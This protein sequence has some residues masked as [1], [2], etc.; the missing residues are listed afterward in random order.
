MAATA[1]VAQVPPTRKST[2][3]RVQATPIQT[4]APRSGVITLYG[5]GIRIQVERGHLMLNDGIADERQ[6]FRLPRV[7]HELERL[8][9]IG[10]DGTVSLSALR[11]LSDQNA[12]FVMLDRDGKVV[13]VTGPVCPSDARLR[14]AQALSHSSD[15]AFCIAREL[16][17]RKLAGQEKVA[18]ETLSKPDVAQEIV[19]WRSGLAE[20]NTIDDVRRIE[21]QAAAEYWSAWRNLPITFPKLDLVR[22]P[23]HWRRFDTRKSVLS[24]SQRLATNPVNA[25]LNY[26]YAILEAESRL[27]LSAMGLD[28]G[29][30]FIHMDAPA[31]DSLACDLMESVRAQVDRYVLDWFLHH[32]L[33]REWFFE[34]RDGNCRL[35]APFAIQLSQTAR[36]WRHAVAPVAEWIARTLWKRE[37]PQSVAPPTRLTQARKRTAKRVSIEVRAPRTPKRQTLCRKCGKQIGEGHI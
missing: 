25:M 34:Q 27:A 29:L 15:R 20:A 1:T 13:C 3:D 8:I 10:N 35:M 14:R 11:W 5:Y 12:A 37:S 17:D 33:R 4:V 19:R 9:V 36:M 24:G 2:S 6:Q 18:R 32:P 31:R 16:I 23:E 22:T 30:G 28:P 7:R 21:S 26:L